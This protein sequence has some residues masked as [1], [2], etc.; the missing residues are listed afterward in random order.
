[1]SNFDH[2]N[3]HKDYYLDHNLNPKP[4]FLNTKISKQARVLAYTPKKQTIQHSTDDP[5]V[6]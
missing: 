4:I 3:V 2:A 6:A 1:M 5:V